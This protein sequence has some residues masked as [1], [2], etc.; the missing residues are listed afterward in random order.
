[1]SI[2][3]NALG[4][5]SLMRDARAQSLD[6]TFALLDELEKLAVEAADLSSLDVLPEKVR[7]SLSRLDQVIRNEIENINGIT[8]RTPAP[9]DPQH[10]GDQ[11]GLHVVATNPHRDT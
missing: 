6:A 3:P 7:V 5:Q 9:H 1:M 2:R 11:P 10:P 4:I 8:Q